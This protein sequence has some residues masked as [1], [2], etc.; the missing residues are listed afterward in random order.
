VLHSRTSSHRWPVPF[1]R[2]LVAVSLLIVGFLFATTASAVTNGDFTSGID[3]WSTS[4]DTSVVGG[5]LVLSDD[6]PASSGAWQVAASEA[7]RMLLEFDVL[8]ALS[9]FSP[10]DPF[11][12]PDLFAASIYLFDDPTGFDPSDGTALGAVSVLSIDWDGPFD[13]FADVVP[14]DRGG[15]WLH[16]SLAFDSSYA[17]YAPAFELFELGFVGGDSTVRI[18]DVVITPVPEPGTAILLLLG[19]AGLGLDRRSATA[20]QAR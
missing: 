5:E 9:S 13:V 8:G 16:V 10:T 4:G 6:G 7:S 11:G 20:Q 14:A 1:L 19:L 12:F 17:Y 15:D 3:A 2:I 18:D